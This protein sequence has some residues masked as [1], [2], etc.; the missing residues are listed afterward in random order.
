MAK[1]ERRGGSLHEVYELFDALGQVSKFDLLDPDSSEKFMKEVK[2]L[3]EEG[4]DQPQFNFGKRVEAMFEFVAASLSKCQLVKKEDAGTHFTPSRKQKLQPPD[5]SVVTQDGQQVLVE[6][7][8]H[9][10]NPLKPWSIRLSDLRALQRYAKL[11][12]RPLYFA[13]FW[14]WTR[15]WT[16]VPD[17]ILIESG[18][19][20]CLEFTKA[21][22]A[23]YMSMF[24]GDVMI[25]TTPPLTFRVNC[26]LS[27]ERVV[28]PDG[29]THF[30][31]ASVDLL[32]AGK[33]LDQPIE[34]MIAWYLLY[35]GGWNCNGWEAVVENGEL[36]AT[37]LNCIPEEPVQEQNFQ[38]VG[39]LSSM[40]SRHYDTLTIR[41][42]KVA[43][44]RAEGSS[45]QLGVVIPIDYK[46]D[47][48]P[49][50]RFLLQPTGVVLTNDGDM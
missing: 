25:G 12:Q 41:N 35:Y 43:K 50:W 27:K 28:G 1:V 33:N 38:F 47:S 20:A 48:L 7:K 11:T 17:N 26:D 23:N 42:G 9:H 3:F 21:L 40:M 14:S 24:L 15:I 46:G 45:D 31:I 36:V 44:H 39:S 32:C 8:N 4:R 34:R 6:V 13:I 29:L 18:G 2:R 22:R 16:L 30:T 19:K 49:L 37:E 10:V 5:Y